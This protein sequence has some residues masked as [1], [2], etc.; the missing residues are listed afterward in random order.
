MFGTVQHTS[1]GYNAALYVPRPI[2]TQ[3]PGCL[4][5][6]IKMTNANAEF[7]NQSTIMQQEVTP[8]NS[9]HKISLTWRVH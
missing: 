9:A 8:A 4:P 7:Q 3:L 5:G 2:L 1:S 6:I